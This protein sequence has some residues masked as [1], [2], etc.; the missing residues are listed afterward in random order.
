MESANQL[1][2]D[3][4]KE[5]ETFR[6]QAREALNRTAQEA[7]DPQYRLGDRV[8]LE[9]RH[10][11]LPYQT[12]KLAPKRHGPFT[13][14][15]EVSP[16]AYRLKLPDTWTI[17]DVFHASLLTP[18][19]ETDAHGT[20]FTRPHPD[21]IDGDEEY[22]VEDVIGHRR[23]R[24]RLQYL[25]KWKGYSSADNSWEPATSL[26]NARELVTRY[27]E[28]TPRDAP[29]RDKRRRVSATGRAIQT[30]SA[31]V[32]C[33]TPPPPLPSPP[34]TPSRRSSHTAPGHPAQRRG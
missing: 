29:S 5:A 15:Q 8:W 18:Y 3:R 14:M 34:P 16:V 28:G 7:P 23:Y 22:E 17:H 10:L 9:A 25:I 1:T 6:A 13:I 2:A 31:Q 33:P 27:H 21:L 32:Q 4:R 20:N 30:H 11:A 24:G 26:Q 12:P 19:R